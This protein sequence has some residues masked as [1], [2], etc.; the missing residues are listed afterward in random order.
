MPEVEFRE[1]LPR[2]AGAPLPATDEVVM[3]SRTRK[4]HRLDPQEAANDRPMWKAPCG[5]AYGLRNFYRL[6]APP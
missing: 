3:H 2:E 5:W 4:V 6:S 1:A